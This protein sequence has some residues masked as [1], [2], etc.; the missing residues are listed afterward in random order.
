MTASVLDDVAGLGEKRKQRLLDEVG[1]IR[2]L[3]TA[4]LDRLKSFSWLPDSVVEA[5]YEKLHSGPT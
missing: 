2:A 1:G 3:K 5:I 4:E